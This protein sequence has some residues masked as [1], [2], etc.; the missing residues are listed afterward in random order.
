MN[1]TTTIAHHWNREEVE[2]LQRNA[3][4]NRLTGVKERLSRWK[5]SQGIDR[6]AVQPDLKM[7]MGTG[8]KAGAAAKPDGLALL[9]IIT[10]QQQW[11]SHEVAVDRCEAISVV[12]PDPVSKPATGI[13][14]C[15][16]DTACQR[17]V[18]RAAG[19]LSDVDTGVRC[20]DA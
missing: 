15:E 20:P 8:R 10:N 9:D 5:H 19:A 3:E 18:H 13:S 11:W 16:D 17:G 12:D 7:E 4:V 1:D 2:A 6:R 14:S